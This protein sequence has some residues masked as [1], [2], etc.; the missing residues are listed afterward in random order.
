MATVRE[1]L[2]IN[3]TAPNTMNDVIAWLA[4]LVSVTDISDD[5][6]ASSLSALC[7]SVSLFLPLLSCSFSSPVVSRADMRVTVFFD[8]L[9][10]AVVRE[11]GQAGEV[12][13]T[14]DGGGSFFVRYPTR[15][16]RECAVSPTTYRPR[17]LDPGVAKTLGRTWGCPR[18]RA[19]QAV[20]DILQGAKPATPSICALLF[21]RN[22]CH[23][24]RARVRTHTVQR[25]HTHARTHTTHTYI[26]RKR[27]CLSVRSNMQV[28]AVE[29]TATQLS[30]VARGGESVTVSSTPSAAVCN[31]DAQWSSKVAEPSVND[32][33]ESPPDIE[34]HMAELRKCIGA[35]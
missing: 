18:D 31:D 15:I 22:S 4:T 11:W 6:S 14:R 7:F 19:L 10:G 2:V 34:R 3:H 25:A 35:C 16:C 5:R 21:A 17:H 9:G 8:T 23:S 29:G 13:A 33:D 28:C 30:E 24:S 26:V 1:V 12:L 27:S 32:L 20:L